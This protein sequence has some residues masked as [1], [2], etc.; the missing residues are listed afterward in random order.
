MAGHTAIADAGETLVDLLREELGGLIEND[1]QVELRS[2]EGVSDSDEVRLTLYL[3]RVAENGELRNQRR[4]AVA[5]SP[6]R[7]QPAPLALDLYY[8]L[9]AHPSSGS[10]GE[11][12]RTRTQ[13]LML[14]RAMQILQDNAILRSTD[15]FDTSLAADRELHLSV[16]PERMEDVTSIWNTFSDKPYEPSVAYIV[17]PVLIDST[18]ELPAARVETVDRQ[19][20]SYGVA[21]DADAGGETSN[22]ES[23]GG[24]GP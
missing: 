4:Q 17:G 11:T 19:Y 2:P 3:Y 22:S 8:L 15:L 14:G 24:A 21:S 13:H 20:R 6:D 7:L 1:E 10:S 23:A 16:Y 12:S 5:E 18:E 9:T